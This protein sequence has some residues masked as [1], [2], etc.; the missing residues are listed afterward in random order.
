M[1]CEKYES[2]E[3]LDRSR[4]VGEVVHCLMNDNT[5]F[6]IAKEIVNLGY[7][8]GLFEN[9]KIMPEHDTNISRISD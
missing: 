3:P 6:D 4:L 9:V 2:L 5:L 1:L 7:K 8:R